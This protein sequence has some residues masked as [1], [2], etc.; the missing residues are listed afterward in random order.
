VVGILLGATPEEVI[1]VNYYRAAKALQSL[2]REFMNMVTRREIHIYIHEIRKNRIL[3]P[4]L[5][6]SRDEPCDNQ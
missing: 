1:E 4:R 2:F 6:I 5:D 3:S